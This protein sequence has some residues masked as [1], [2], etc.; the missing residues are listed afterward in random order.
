MFHAFF[1]ALTRCALLVA[2]VFFMN[3]QAFAGGAKM[4]VSYEIVD[5]I[6]IT[7]PL[8]DKPGDPANG[9]RIFFNVKTACNACHAPSGNAEAS[10]TGE[11]WRFLANSRH[12][13]SD[14]QLRLILVNPKALNPDS[15]MPAYYE[16]GQDANGQTTPSRLKAQE[17]ED[18]I[19]YL[20]TL[21]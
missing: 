3:E 14:G 20:K 19:A 9:K 12:F 11:S 17:I 6:S 2:I 10:N 8:T 15:V 7:K 18:V 21:E 4:P 13:Y 16:P 5:G 1:V